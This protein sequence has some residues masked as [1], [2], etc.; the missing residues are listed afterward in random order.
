[1]NTSF[2]SRYFAEMMT[3]FKL[4]CPILSDKNPYTY[5]SK[6]SWNGKN[7][8]VWIDFILENENEKIQVLNQFIIRPKMILKNKKIDLADHYGIALKIALN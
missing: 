5:S 1:M 8:N 2:K 3:E 4:Y 7:Y 6:N